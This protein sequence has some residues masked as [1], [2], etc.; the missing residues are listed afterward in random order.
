MPQF[1]RRGPGAQGRTCRIALQ[2]I[3]LWRRIIA[4]LRGSASGL[5]AAVCLWWLLRGI[6][7]LLRWIVLFTHLRCES[8]VTLRG[9]RRHTLNGELVMQAD[10]RMIRATMAL[11]DESSC[12]WVV[13]LCVVETHCYFRALDGIDRRN[14]KRNASNLYLLGTAINNHWHTRSQETVTQ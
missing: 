6:I 14:R 4:S 7:A 9:Q 3:S 2:G 13:S 12:W 11:G 1:V 10:Q 8:A 5:V